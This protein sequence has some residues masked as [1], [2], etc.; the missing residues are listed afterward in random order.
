MRNRV[1]VAL[2]GGVDSSVSALLL[3]EQ[4]Y[5]VVGVT[6]LLWADDEGVCDTV[7]DGYGFAG[8]IATVEKV[9]QVLGIPLRVLDLRTEFRH[10]V[11]DYFCREYAEGRTPN[12]CIPCNKYIKFG[13]LLNY[14]IA[15]GFDYLATGH[16]VRVEQ[17]NGTYHLIKGKDINRDQSYV[18]YTLGQDKLRRVLFPLGEY[19]KEE[20]RGLARKYGL[21]NS[22]RSDSQDL[23]FTAD[24]KRFLRHHLRPREGVI[25][26]SQGQIVGRHEGIMFYTIGQR[27]G[28]G[29]AT[30]RPTYV[31]G[32]DAANNVLVVGR[33]G[34]LFKSRFVVKEVSWV[35]G[36][37]TTGPVEAGV[38]IRYKTSECPATLCP[39]DGLVE[40][41]LH[42]AQ[43]A[44]TPGQAAV[45]Y[46]GEEVIGGGIIDE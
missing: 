10:H 38:K 25:V 14:A 37:P 12:P 20:V 5:E 43:C 30:G 23:C 35:S 19:S 1:L 8:H 33:K 7:S 11:V 9:C 42:K 31:I 13:F 6:M 34:R 29:L 45:F 15:S 16:Y 27:R 28:L 3:K 41:V 36:K 17:R 24:R 26:D 40:V 46:L 39:R 22:E 44:V 4:G 32:I 18:L 21:P 2:S